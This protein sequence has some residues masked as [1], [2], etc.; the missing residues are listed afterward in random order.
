M[1]R[2]CLQ[3][4]IASFPLLCAWVCELQPGM[5]AEEAQR[6][7]AKKLTAILIRQLR[8]SGF[9]EPND[10]ADCGNNLFM[11]MEKKL[12]EPVEFVVDKVLCRA[13][14]S[15]QTPLPEST[16]L[17]LLR[18][19]PFYILVRHSELQS[20]RKFCARLL[21]LEDGTEVLGV[22]DLSC[23]EDGN[24]PIQLAYPTFRHEQHVR[25][26][27]LPE[28]DAA[29]AYAAHVQ[30]IRHESF[31]IRM[32]FVASTARYIA[33][34][35]LRARKK[36]RDLTPLEDLP[37]WGHASPVDPGQD[38][39][40]LSA[41]RAVGTLPRELRA[42]LAQRYVKGLSWSEIAGLRNV[43]EVK[44]RKDDSRVLNR[45]SEAIVASKPGAP[46]GAV[47]RVVRWLKEML[48]TILERL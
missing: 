7:M 5:S 36:E 35:H 13:A 31:E 45:L 40:F 46:E 37:P 34:D 43:T 21:N 41:K 14:E 16:V 12:R 15:G 39:E 4:S 44:V 9:W 28:G 10:I 42:Q 8:L 48:P 11:L 30:A 18:A 25:V 17:H 2:A 22:P 24:L 27:L 1:Q 19:V 38:I 20:S 3:E 23:A 26:E 33:R 32:G 29:Y 47:P 6:D